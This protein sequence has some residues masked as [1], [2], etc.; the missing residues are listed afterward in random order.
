MSRTQTG[1]VHTDAGQPSRF[2]IFQFLF[3]VVVSMETRRVLISNVETDEFSS[4][5]H[6]E[7]V[8]EVN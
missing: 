7:M 4:S 1:S 6:S 3:H 2:R 5:L 8:Q